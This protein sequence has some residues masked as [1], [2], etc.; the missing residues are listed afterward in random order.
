MSD[1]NFQMMR[2]QERWFDKRLAFLPAYTRKA[3]I[4]EYWRREAATNYRS[5]N[6]WLRKITEYAQAAF[7]QSAFLRPLTGGV[8]ALYDDRELKGL[9]E[10]HARECHIRIA[11]MDFS[12][13]VKYADR[14][15]AV[16]RMLAVYGEEHRV[17][18][19]YRDLK[20]KPIG[21][22]ES[23]LLKMA[24]ANWWHRQLKR[25]RRELLEYVQ[26][27]LERV[28]R[29]ISPYISKSGLKAHRDQVRSN[30]EYL[31][32][33]EAVNDDG[34]AISLASMFEKSSASPEKR[35]IELMVRCRG[36]EEL[37]DEM[38]YCAEF[39][40][41]T[42]PSK[43]HRHSRKWAGASPKDAQAYMVKMWARIRTELKDCRIEY[44]G[45]RVAEPHH[46]GTP[47]WHLLTFVQKDQRGVML[48]V[49][50]SHA[51]RED[52]DE[53]GA[54][55]A[56]FDAV[57][58]DR[59]KGSAT[60]YIAKY[61]SKNINGERMAGADDIDEEAQTNAADGAERVRAW[62]STW[63]LRQFQFFGW[64][65]VSV[66]REL[67]RVG[68]I[69]SCPALEALRGAAD[70]A[71]WGEFQKL[72]QA[73][74]VKLT[75]EDAGVN[76]YNEPVKRVQGVEAKNGES[77]VTRL[78]RWVV[79]KRGD[80]SATRT[81]VNN[82]GNGM[83]DNDHGAKRPGESPIK[84]IAATYPSS[85]AGEPVGVKTDP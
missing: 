49:M 25:Q 23:A 7:Q 1:L 82:C 36:M 63:S 15:V 79:R 19:P 74:P 24:C 21:L 75:Y 6:I 80:S 9:A 84:E 20:K 26:I 52:C 4:K 72:I 81:R 34:D 43:Y 18:V 61:I 38:G 8:S 44:F 68:V 85:K 66:W 58:I 46:D 67:R 59:S 70:A 83:H 11:E 14:V 5:A 76:E 22:L 53:A 33:M 56:R 50:R 47:H 12:D 55:K 48:D 65:G 60:G 37:A 40:T 45:V 78:I 41:M 30:Q 3:M 73:T 31:A 27:A 35:R 69:E 64:S 42:T 2:D 13:D 62:A 10:A 77:V 57:S 29:R 17:N 54:A 16:Y 71:K 32:L 51:M 39:I 28:N